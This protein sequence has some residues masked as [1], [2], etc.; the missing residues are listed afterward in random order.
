MKDKT[1]A[2][3]DARTAGNSALATEV[4]GYA[5]L[6]NVDFAAIVGSELDG[7]EIGFDRVKI[8]SGGAMMFEV[9]AESGDGTES[10]KEFSGVILHHHPLNAYYKT[11]Y[12]GGN[13]PPDCGS[14]DGIIGAGDPGGLC[15]ECPLNQYGSGEGG[16]NACKNRRRVY[17]L[18]DEE[19]FPLLL[20]LPTGSLENFTRYVKRQ[21]TKMRKLHN[22]VTRFSLKKVNNAGGIAYSQAVLELDRALSP[23]EQRFINTMSEQVK[24]YSA[25]IGLDQ[26]QY[27]SSDMDVDPETG[28]VLGAGGADKDV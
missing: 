6:A 16:G 20:S 28:E 25:K 11:K 19:V 24:A 21:L 7:L 8:P 27:G 5:A 10:V 12:T 23:D 18:R 3:T 9:P 2:E 17:V 14:F 15:R 4:S 26:E 13:A 22:V 1:K